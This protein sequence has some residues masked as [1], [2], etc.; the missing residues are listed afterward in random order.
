MRVVCSGQ[1]GDGPSQGL[2]CFLPVPVPRKD[3]RVVKEGLKNA[4]TSF[5]VGRG[6]RDGLW[7]ALSEGG[8]IILVPAIL[9][10]LLHTTTLLDQK[11]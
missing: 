10:I 6:R 4:Y 7:G 2:S 11:T 3:S 8:G 9:L 5:F 1:A